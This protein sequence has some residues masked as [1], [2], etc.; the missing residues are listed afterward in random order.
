MV[1][2]YLMGSTQSGH[3]SPRARHSDEAT[4]AQ[5]PGVLVRMLTAMGCNH[6]RHG[7]PQLHL[8]EATNG[9]H[10]SVQNMMLA[11][12]G[13]G[14]NQFGRQGLRHFG[15]TGER[16]PSVHFPSLPSIRSNLP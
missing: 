11:S 2:H 4:D 7:T 13:Y 14:Q 15:V 6:D 5:C 1:T 3:R 9:Q 10:P 12:T 8:S 16:H